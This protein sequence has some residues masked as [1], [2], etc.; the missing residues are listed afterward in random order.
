ML[1]SRIRP[2]MLEAGHNMVS[3]CLSTKYRPCSL[4]SGIFLTFATI[5]TPNEQRQCPY[6]KPN[7][8]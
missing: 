6:H 5:E 4:R 8:L 7:Y 3:A 2:T 1:M